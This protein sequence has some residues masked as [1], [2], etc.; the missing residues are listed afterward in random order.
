MALIGRPASD[1]HLVARREQETYGIPE[2][3]FKAFKAQWDG[4]VSRGI[5]W[6]FGLFQWDQWWKRELLALGP[7]AKRGR[8]KGHYMMARFNDAGAYEHGNVYAATASQNANDI[9]ADVRAAMI[10]KGSET[11]RANG[12]PRGAH[13]K[14]GN[15]H[16]MAHP[17]ETELG[18]FPSIRLASQ[19]HG[20]SER[21]GRSWVRRGAWT[22]A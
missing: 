15:R 13:L 20:F 1:A 8:R 4:A 9:P 16:P 19:A 10:E 22:L 21:T 11:A 2:H 5:P 12:R 6:R 17:V 7:E 3:V 18:V 14:L